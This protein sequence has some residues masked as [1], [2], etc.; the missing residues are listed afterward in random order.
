M[1]IN[2]I[3]DPDLLPRGRADVK[4]QHIEAAPSE[5]KTRIHVNLSIT[6]F[7]PSDKPNLEVAATYPDGHIAASVTIIETMQREF[8][9]NLHLQEGPQHGTYNVEARLFYEDGVIQDRAQTSLEIE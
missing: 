4:I 1:D 5:D 8:G 9:V 7:A 3:S 2:F 6:P